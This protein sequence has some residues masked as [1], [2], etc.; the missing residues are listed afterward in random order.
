[1]SVSGV[2]LNW[3]D[4][5]VHKLGG[6]QVT[7]RQPLLN[8][9]NDRIGEDRYCH[10]QETLLEAVYRD[11]LLALSDLDLTK[12]TN[13]RLQK[14]ELFKTFHYESFDRTDVLPLILRHTDAVIPA[15]AIL[16]YELMAARSK[17]Q[18][19][20]LRELTEGGV[21][22]PGG[23]S[24][25][26]SQD[27]ASEFVGS[28]RHVSSAAPSPTHPEPSPRNAPSSS[29]SESN[30]PN[31]TSSPQ[32]ASNA[33][34]N[35]AAASEGYVHASGDETESVYSFQNYETAYATDVSSGSVIDTS[36]REEVGLVGPPRLQTEGPPPSP[37]LDP[38][39]GA[40]SEAST[41][42]PPKTEEEEL[43]E[44]EVVSTDDE[45]SDIGSIS[46]SS[47]PKDVVVKHVNPI[48]EGE[49]E[50][51]NFSS[52]AEDTPSP[53]AGPS[54][55]MEIV[56]LKR[57]SRSYPLPITSSWAPPSSCWS[58]KR[59]LKDM[60]R[61]PFRFCGSPGEYRPT[62]PE[63]EEEEAR[64]G[65]VYRKSVPGR[66]THPGCLVFSPNE[67]KTQWTYNL[68]LN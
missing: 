9:I 1:M 53:V 54:R 25:I 59:P 23:D 32:L 30:V 31:A 22:S 42:I 49:L 28:P 41:I 64:D 12:R 68:G 43:V 61:K 67:E 33:P 37:D 57:R 50:T 10:K 18:E 13:I 17:Q 5:L 3:H 36:D 39:M 24:G 58:C 44:F 26:G 29:E 48:P 20:R 4:K 2:L 19:Q 65:C 11:M 51:D 52:D 63:T 15:S 8:F 27:V 46:S 55:G 6:F 45:N 14:H 7:L 56:P 40:D 60:D 34:G 21:R 35:E 66:S 16:K 62:Q 38:A 47:E